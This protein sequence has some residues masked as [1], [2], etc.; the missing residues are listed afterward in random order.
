MSD[1]REPRIVSAQ[2]GP[3]P[4]SLLGPMPKVTVTFDDGTTKELFEFYPDE[5][6]FGPTEFEGL[7]EAEARELRH[8]KDAA[9]LRS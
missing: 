3:M 8:K 7:T 9:Y 6:S 2:V 1:V 4:R 5:I